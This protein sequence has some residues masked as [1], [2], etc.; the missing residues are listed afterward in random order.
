MC[1]L[2]KMSSFIIKVSDIGTVLKKQISLWQI[3]S[4]VAVSSDLQ[5]KYKLKNQTWS[6]QI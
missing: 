5:Q 2:G 6:F 4:Y 3:S 1:Y